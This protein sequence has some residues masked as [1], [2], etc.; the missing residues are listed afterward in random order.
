MRGSA[1]GEFL[2]WWM[3]RQMRA[4]KWDETDPEAAAFLDALLSG[5]GDPVGIEIQQGRPHS[6][7]ARRIVKRALA[8][9]DDLGLVMAYI[10]DDGY[11]TVATRVLL[12]KHYHK[13]RDAPVGTSL[14]A[15]YID[16]NQALRWSSE[17]TVEIAAA[18]TAGYG[19]MDVGKRYRT[20]GS[21]LVARAVSE[22]TSVMNAPGLYRRCE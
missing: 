4:G 22:L 18:L 1:M 5:D 15:V 19:A 6:A 17:M 7:Q 9:L 3:D 14:N 21:R 12:S 2:L 8:A 11:T 20:N 10:E 13:L 16:L